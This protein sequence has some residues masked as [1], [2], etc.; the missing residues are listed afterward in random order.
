MEQLSP[1]F[2]CQEKILRVYDQGKIVS[3]SYNAA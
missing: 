2:K 3:L 1:N